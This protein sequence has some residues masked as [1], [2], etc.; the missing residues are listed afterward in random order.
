MSDAHRI[1]PVKGHYE[2]YDESGNF[3]ISGDTYNECY[4]DLLEMLVEEARAG[5][6]MENIRE[7]VSA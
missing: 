3:V 1:I 6:E 4:N 7:K 5:I 2:A